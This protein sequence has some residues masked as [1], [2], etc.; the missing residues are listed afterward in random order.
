MS[1]FPRSFIEADTPATSFHPLF[2][3]L[4]DFDNYNQTT[5]QGGSSQRQHGGQ[6]TKI[7]T[8]KFDVREVQNAY[9]LHG[10]L[11][12]IDQKD[13]SIEFTD[14]NTLTIR[15]R[16]ERSYTAGTPPQGFIEGGEQAKQIEN[17]KDKEHQPTAEDDPNEP[18]T[19]P[20]EGQVAKQESKKPEEPQARYWVSERSVGE[21][22]RTF[23]FPGRVDHDGVTASMKNGI[24]SIVVPKAKKRETRKITISS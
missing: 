23:T 6:Q 12:G 17:H 8:P 16:S 1:F 22:A 4:D 21:F 15:G 10:E 5:K 19:P 24:L 14:E 18:A 9:E 2:R 7:F 11:P 20:A 3:L 13:V